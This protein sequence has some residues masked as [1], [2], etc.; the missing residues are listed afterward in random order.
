[1]VCTHNRFGKVI[2]YKDVFEMMYI[3]QDYA[4]IR[5]LTYDNGGDWELKK[6]VLKK[7]IY[8]YPRQSSIAQVEPRTGEI[9]KE[10]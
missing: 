3:L 5:L 6:I 9:T 2:L 4:N 10:A 8:N 7:C 1:M